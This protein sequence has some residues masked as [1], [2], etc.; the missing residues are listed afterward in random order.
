[1][2]EEYR[3]E[4][5]RVGP[6]TGAYVTVYQRPGEEP[7]ADLNFFDG[8]CSTGE[9]SLLAAALVKAERIMIRWRTEG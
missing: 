9:V 7:K 6:D 1:M 2:T 5:V 3:R 8:D 4:D